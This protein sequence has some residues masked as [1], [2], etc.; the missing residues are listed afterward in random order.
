MRIEDHNKNPFSTP[1]GYFEE[2]NTRIIGA[3]SNSE[4]IAKKNVVIG[5]WKRVLSYAAMLAIVAL[6][7]GELL[8]E[9]VRKN[10]NMATVQEEM[11][12]DNE[13]YD[14]LL[15]NYTIDD[16][17]FYCCLTEYE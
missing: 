16:Y 12:D 15:E 7:A 8:S 11:S 4:P 9:S 3:T 6:I 14:T 2:L 10:G 5:N 13:F 17:T 1:T